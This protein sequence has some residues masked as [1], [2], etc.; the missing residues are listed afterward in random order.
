VGA[1][2]FIKGITNGDITDENGE[3]G[4]LTAQVLPF[5]VVVSYVGY[6]K[7]EVVITESKVVIR[8]EQ[9]SNDLDAVVVT[10]RRR[11]ESAQDIP[12]AV[13]VVSGAKAADAGAFNVNRLKELVPSVQLY[14]SNPRNTGINIRGL[15]S[16]FGL[17]NDGLDP[18]VGFYVDGVYFARPAAAT[19]DFI[20]IERIEVLRGPQGTLF[21]KNTTSGAFNITT[22][23]PSF[24]P[25]ADFELSYGNY[26]FMQAKA[27]VTGAITKKLAGR[28]SFSG[29]N[30]N[31]LLE[32][33]VTKKATNSI[34]N[35]GLRGQL[36]YKPIEKVSI[37]LAIDN[38]RQRPD[39]YAQVIAGVT[40]TKRPAYRQ[41]NNIIKDLNYTVPSLNAFDR[42]IDHD[43]QPPI[44]FHGLRHN[45]LAKER[46]ADIPGNHQAFAP[47]LLHLFADVGRDGHQGADIGGACRQALFP[48]VHSFHDPLRICAGHDIR[49]Y[50]HRLHPFRFIAQ[51]HR[52]CP[53]ISGF[54]LQATAIGN[55]HRSI[56]G[57]P[58]TIA[59]SERLHDAKSGGGIY[60]IK[61]FGARSEQVPGAGMHRKHNA[62]AK[63]SRHTAKRCQKRFYSGFICSI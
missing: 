8:L 25:G 11:S 61:H 51:Y 44:R 7:K 50:L 43:I 63:C 12:I 35:F 49:T 31:G 53:E 15:G 32:N 58:E 19:L 28:F 62:F 38:T 40:E 56:F 23:R 18:G 29:T 5:T 9:I 57:A 55:Y 22:R 14:T 37:L 42:I 59:V 6:Y 21:G 27:S 13:S 33:I 45:V 46:V 17:T 26:S 52:R 20:D 3:F 41:F 4:L 48:S 10:S 39:G 24:T 16:P 2:V 54:L 60:L 1:N 36:L 30:R 47:F 34:N